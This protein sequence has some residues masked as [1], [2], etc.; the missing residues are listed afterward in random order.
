MRTQ[1]PC[2]V[3]VGYEGKTIGDLI[4][5][6]VALEVLVLVD[7]RLMPLSRKP[8][9]SKTKLG[10]ALAAAGIRYVHHGALGNPKDNRAG[11]RAGQPASI[12]R[13]SELLDSEAAG[14][15]LEHVAEMLEGG[16]VA[17]LCFEQDHAECHRA[18]VARRLMQ[19]RTDITVIEA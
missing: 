17:L 14:T 6:L 5:R 4:E 8:G 2:L 9:L 18:M 15:A 10:D 3:S 11:F 16:V 12:Q 13:Y 1:L 7:V 19:V